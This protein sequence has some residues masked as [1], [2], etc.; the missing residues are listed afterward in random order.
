MR[1]LYLPS[2]L[3]VSLLLAGCA[4]QRPAELPMTDAPSKYNDRMLD[5]LGQQ[6]YTESQ[7][8]YKRQLD[9]YESRLNDLER[10][11]KGLEDALSA[12]SYENDLTNAPPD[13]AES[14][15]IGD[16]Q[17]ATY[18]AQARAAQATARADNRNAIIENSRDAALAEAE[19]RAAKRI[20]ELERQGSD[21]DSLNEQRI[22]VALANAESERRVASEIAEI[23]NQIEALKADYRS[24]IALRM[25]DIDQRRLQI[26]A[27]ESEIKVVENEVE[28]LG[29]R[30]DT[31]VR[32]HQARLLILNQEAAKLADIRSKLLNPQADK[33]RDMS[34]SP[35]SLKA[36]ILAEL[37]DEKARITSKARLEIAETKTNA[38]LEVATVV[39]PVVTGRRVYAGEYGK[40]PEHYVHRPSP[41]VKQTAVAASKPGDHRDGKTSQQAPRVNPA[42][43]AEKSILVV[44]RFEPVTGRSASH[45][46]RNSVGS[47]VITSNNS[48]AGAAKPIVVAP[49]TRTAYNVVYKYSEKNSFDQFQRYLKAYGV[50]DATVTEN[51]ISNEYTIWAGRYFSPEDAARRVDHLNRV[52]S[53]SHAS[54]LRQEVPR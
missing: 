28:D 16:F 43:K 24:Q 31:A 23:T 25:R 52:T 49:M 14:Q 27:L 48:S 38:A 46:E 19:G 36:E 20:A 44:D 45:A 13:S 29:A 11:R 22:V 4:G 54:V 41:L 39:A 6:R 34:A 47:V 21:S 5:A 8:I 18:A 42:P 9:D 3:T 2:L 7:I 12:A 35:A 10:Q 33:N 37:A 30:E 53:T 51:P 50:T 17:S 26:S 32:P 1:M 40:E 15:R